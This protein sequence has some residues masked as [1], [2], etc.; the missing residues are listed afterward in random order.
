MIAGTLGGDGDVKV[1]NALLVEIG[2]S[3]MAFTALTLT[4]NRRCN[5]R[6]MSADKELPDQTSKYSPD[7][8]SD[9]YRIYR[10]IAA[11]PVDAGANQLS[12]ADV[13]FDSAKSS[14][15]GVVGGQTVE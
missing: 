8:D 10:V 11:P 13:R 12:L 14:E 4:K 6:L 7:S 9:K 3:P 5:V 15:R 2:L 1:S